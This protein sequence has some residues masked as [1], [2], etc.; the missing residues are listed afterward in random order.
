MHHT[1]GQLLTVGPQN[2]QHIAM[3]VA[4]MEHNRHAQA[5]RQQQLLFKHLL[6]NVPGRQVV[7]IIQPDFSYA[8]DALF[9]L[10]P[11]QT[12]LAFIR[13]EF[14]LV[15]MK[16]HNAIDIFVL[17]GQVDDA[18]AGRQVAACQDA[19]AHPVFRH[20][21]HYLIPILVKAFILQ[22]A[23]T[24]KQVDRC[25]GRF[26]HYRIYAPSSMP[27]STVTSLSVLSPLSDAHRIMP[28]LLMP[29]S[30]AGFRLLTSTTCLPTISSGV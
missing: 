3:S 11:G 10:P 27:A 13:P 7:V 26:F 8:Y 5:A 25:E 29:R 1:G 19:A 30:L 4:D 9:L 20:A 16:T 15:G 2:I 6:L 22:M 14:G 21:G 18:L 24:V 23:M 28:S 17:P 12:R